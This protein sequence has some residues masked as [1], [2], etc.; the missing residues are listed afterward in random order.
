[1]MKTKGGISPLAAWALAFGS[2]VG[3]GAF[4]MPGRVFLPKA[5]PLG[6][7][8][9]IVAGGEIMAVFAWNYHAM[10]NRFP[11]PGGAYA[12]AKKA[13]GI[14]HGF[15]CAWFLILTYVAIVW[16]NATALAVVARHTFG[17]ALRFGFSYEIAGYEVCLG[18]IVVAAVAI[19]ASAAC[20]LR[21]RVA[22]R[23]QS[24]LA[25]CLALGVAACFAAV[26][27]RHAG[28]GVP[29]APAFA[30]DGGHP[31]LQILKIVAMSPWLFIG[32]E[33]ISHSSSEFRFNPG[34]TFTILATALVASVLAY[35]MLALLPALLPAYGA[36]GW[37]TSLARLAGLSGHPQIATFAAVRE[38]L[39]RAGVAAIGCTMLCAIFT[40]L[41][42]NTF[43]TSRLLAAMA[44]DG[45]LPSW[46]S[47]RNGDGSPSNAVIAIAAV[48]AVIPFLG[49]TAIGFIVDVSTVG[50]A[51]AYAYT[52]A[53]AF[54]LAGDRDRLTR[55]T[56]LGGVIL[57]LAVLILFIVPNYASGAM[58]ATESY[59]LLV[60]WCL[61]GFMFFRSVFRRD[62]HGR[63]GKSTIVW[64]AILTM[65]TMMSLLWM[66]QTTSDTTRLVFEEVVR[67]HDSV[68]PHA[69]F[70]EENRWK[71]D[72]KRLRG[73]TNTM[74]LR[75]GL[76]QT[77]LMALAFAILFNL[78]AMLLKREKAL[79]REK[80]LRQRERDQE[81]EKS[82]ARSFFFS[83]VSHDI[84][85][86]LNAII[87]FSEM[88]KAGFRT[89]EEREQAIDAIIVSGQTLLGLINDVLDLSKLESGKMEISPEPTDCPRLMREI[90]DAFRVAGNKPGLE[91]RLGAGAMP[92]LMLD[93][94]R[95]R[96]IVFNLVGN[97]V[98]F[99]EKGHVELRA[100]FERGEGDDDGTFRMEVEDTGCGISEEN[101][102]RI[103]SP[104]VQ[105]GSK[106]SRHGGTGLG[107]S[108]CRQLATAMG[109]DLRITSTL[110][111]GSVFTVSIP[112][113]KIAQEA[114]GEAGGEAAPGQD[115]H[116]PCR[117]LR[118]D[119][120]PPRILLVDDS[121]MNLMVLK[122]ILRK[123]GDYEI[124]LASD[125]REALEI[126][127]APDA[128]P[129]D[130]VLTDLWM[131]NLDGEGLVKAI[132]ANP[133]LSNLRVIVATADVE[134]RGRAIEMG[135]D[136]IML[137]PITSASLAPVLKGIA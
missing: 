137:K 95:L 4:V 31:V 92:R 14:D 39:G 80:T 131:P 73:F 52:S 88:L 79:V 55:L 11:G 81:R 3:W 42:G 70:A 78:H 34:R 123:Y 129:F 43:A 106:V 89:E 54:R 22:G 128:R 53:A 16:A 135:F 98:K 17:E 51:I 45:I 133:A 5:G 120:A 29:V 33:S 94:Q 126:L 67:L 97:A 76:V 136:D 101:L 9:G 111:E 12:Y 37:P 59:L 104:Y 1:M 19:A 132:R 107:L 75:G 8:L 105:V 15:L 99:T 113:V 41:I 38:A 109:G 82:K 62:R 47:R 26:A 134:L 13:F 50:A 64:V 28:G 91:L 69:T 74:L 114:R 93:P 112:H 68:L 2:A 85:T 32:F 40:G 60:L 116:E 125:G 118:A 57:A 127:G 117:V 96:Q 36:A 10:A 7:V 124:A 83:T 24:A 58:M 71:A 72:M 130:L 122:A 27:A 103:A 84:R 6:A 61:I 21:R 86:P 121:K 108:I 30:P 56:G 110:G 63:F 66:R 65:I 119:G 35:A 100:V 18:D 77:G 87:G 25:V 23:V 102:K 48:S 90:M 49:R 20:C 46:H 44:D 115:A